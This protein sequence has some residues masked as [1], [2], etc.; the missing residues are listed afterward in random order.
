MTLTRWLQAM[1][2][3]GI[4][5]AGVGR[6]RRRSGRGPRI[7]SRSNRDFSLRRVI[8]WEG[9]TEEI[10]KNIIAETGAQASRR[11]IRVDKDVPFKQHSAR[12][13]P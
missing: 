10:G 7:Y 13:R 3:F 6:G 4:E 11:N 8:A 5:L 2:T 12:A 1:G 9:E